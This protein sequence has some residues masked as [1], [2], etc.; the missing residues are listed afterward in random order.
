MIKFLRDIVYTVIATH[1]T[2]MLSIYVERND[3]KKAWKHWVRLRRLGM[4]TDM[5]RR[6]VKIFTEEA[7]KK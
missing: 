4:D 3:C 1:N 2:I 6:L 5:I 7:L